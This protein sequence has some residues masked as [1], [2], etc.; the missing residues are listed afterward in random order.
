V[1]NAVFAA[2][3]DPTPRRQLD[4]GFLSGTEFTVTS[5]PTPLPQ[6]APL[7]P[8]AVAESEPNDTLSGHDALT[9]PATVAAA[10]E[11]A[12]VGDLAVRGDGIED[13]YRIDVAGTD[14]LRIDLGWQDGAKNLDLYLLTEDLRVL[15]ET[16]QGTQRSGTEEAVCP[17]LEPGAYYL[18]VT[19]LDT[20]K[21][22]DEP[23]SLGV[24]SDPQTISAAI[25][26]A[27]QPVEVDGAC[28]AIVEFKVT[29]HDNCCLDPD[30]LELQVGAANPTN[31]LSLGSIELDP[32]TVIGP[33]DVEVT[34]RVP[35]SD[36]TSCP[37]QVVIYAQAEDC[38][39]N[40]VATG[41]QGTD[42]STTV[43]DLIPP[44]VG[45]SDEDLFCLWP[46]NH[47]YVCFDD[48][49]FS[50]TIT[51]NCTPTPT[52]LFDACSSDQ[53]D[54]AP[55]GG[56]PNGDGS[57]VHDCIVGA[58]DDDVCARSER[59]GSDPDGRRYAL[60]IEAT[61]AC[62][63]VSPATTM[64]NLYVPHDQSPA[65]VCVAPPSAAAKPLTSQS[66][67]VG[68]ERNDRRARQR[69]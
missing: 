35:V 51:D 65:E 13:V 4:V 61:D 63:N 24:E 38:S 25:M 60:D 64:G 47:R 19:N 67:A 10:L 30:A 36:L 58:G 62:G 31:N 59:A 8:G 50:P 17:E 39:G 37:A 20:T 45:A 9:Y 46:P 28:E 2:G 26:N 55:M 52:W 11:T 54:D 15:N 66:Q 5:A 18:M 7:G 23:Y 21:I 53:P 42:A 43:V 6:N 41:P 3:P 16:G 44:Q 34:G 69:R 56:G 27:V 33:R 57:T 48:G 32:P 12:N 49:A 68:A 22:G 40:L 29:I 14:E 1:T